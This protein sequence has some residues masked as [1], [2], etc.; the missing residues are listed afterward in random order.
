MTLLLGFVPEIFSHVFRSRVKCVFH[1]FVKR[2]MI[3]AVDSKAYV[4]ANMFGIINA[5]GT[6]QDN[7]LNHDRPLR[8]TLPIS[9]PVKLCRNGPD[10]YSPE[11]SEWYAVVLGWHTDDFFSFS[12]PLTILCGSAIQIV[13]WIL[14]HPILVEPKEHVVG[15]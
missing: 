6:L 9:Y 11:F 15:S 10:K 13:S 14:L 3:S 7:G 8:V 12:L 5:F 2:P 1:E 4:R